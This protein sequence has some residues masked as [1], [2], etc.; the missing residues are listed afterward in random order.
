MITRRDFCVAAAALTTLLGRGDVS[1]W[2]RLAVA[3]SLH[4]TDYLAADDFGNVTLLH[5]TDLHAQLKP[6]YFREPSVNLGTGAAR[7]KLP[8]ITGTAFLD[9]FGLPPD[10]PEAHA[11]TSVDFSA[12]AQSYGKMGGLDRIATLVKQIR[13]DRPNKVLLLDGGDSWQG[14][15]TANATAGGDMVAAMETLGIDA[16]TAH[17]EFTYGAERVRTIVDSLS[18]P[19]LAGNIVDAEW[20]EPVFPAY[21]LFERGGA[22]IAVIGQAFPYTPIANPGWMIP[23]WRFGIRERALAANIVAA[24]NDGADVII[25]LSH[26]GFDVDRKLAQRVAGIDIILSGHTHDALPYP[27]RVGKTWLIASGC[28]GKFVS[29]LDLDIA[30]GRL[31]DARYRLIPIFA[32]AIAPDQE[33]A[34]LIKTLRAPYESELQRELAHT[35]TLLYRRGNFNGTV[36]DLFCNALLAEHDSEIAFSPGFR[37]GT[38]LPPQHPFTVEDLHNCC[39]ITYPQTYR[40]LLSGADIKLILEDVADNLFNPDPYYQQ[41]GDMVRLGGMGYRIDPYQKAGARISDMTLLSTGARIDP[42]HDYVV[43]G[44]ASVREN[45]EGPP[46]ADI[47]TAYLRDH[48]IIRLLPS[49]NVKLIA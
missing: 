30:G 24:R 3:Q 16:M 14:S 34:E 41:G 36:D 20:D 32:E 17:W 23:Q 43:A 42:R 21:R 8:H 9:Y 27:V 11:L 35:E 38:S 44:W 6:H 29:R 5:I 33:M 26:N 25:L 49:Q 12:L 7:G 47:V 28:N 22:A 31:R 37:W 48:P 1:S 15:Y 46:I 40:R 2:R 39:A 13:A 18:F 19:F 4:N 45:V 10:S